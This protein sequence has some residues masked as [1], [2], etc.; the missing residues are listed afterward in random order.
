MRLSRLNWTLVAFVLCGWT[1][2]QKKEAPFFETGVVRASGSPDEYH[3]YPVI[4][5]TQGGQL[6]TTW[7]LSDRKTGEAKIVGAFSRDGARTWSEPVTLIDTEKY[8][9]DPNIVID[10]KRILV[11][12]TTVSIPNKID[13]SEVWMTVSEDEGKP[14]SKPVEIKMPYKYFVGKRHIGIQLRSG[15]LVMPFSWD[16]WAEAGTPARTEGE[17]DLQSGVLISE[18]GGRTWTPHGELHIFEPK[19]RP[20]A[21][22]GLDEPAI[23]QLSNG[24]LYMLFRT[25]TSWHY[26]SRSPD[27]GYTWTPPQRSALSGHNTPMA[28]WRL[29]Q[30][31]DEIIVIWNNSPLHRYPLSVAISADG[32]R[33]WS[34]PKNVATSDGPQVSYPGITQASDGTIVAVWQQQLAAGGRDVRWARFN[35]AWVLADAEE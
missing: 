15:K 5:R 25:G 28:L 8:D 6:F 32:G 22:W 34:R 13:K 16:L 27:G 7:T 2:A 35:R 24:E 21:T 1:M 17:M 10:G 19:V 29:D 33:S 23:V 9:A 12:S 11:Y 18:D 3:A 14:W 4:A 31:P 30:K 20:G 26:E